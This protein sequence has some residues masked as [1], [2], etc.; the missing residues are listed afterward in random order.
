MSTKK[1]T[2]ET[3][4]ASHFATDYQDVYG[5]IVKKVLD[6][7]VFSILLFNKF[8]ACMNKGDKSMVHDFAPVL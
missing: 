1:K 4:L 8:P 5:K 7:P 6:L 2:N 3:C